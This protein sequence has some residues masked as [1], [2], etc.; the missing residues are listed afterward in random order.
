MYVIDM[1]VIDLYV[2]DIYVIDLSRE[3]NWL[4]EAGKIGIFLKA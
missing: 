1:Y 3:L 2:I 4:Q